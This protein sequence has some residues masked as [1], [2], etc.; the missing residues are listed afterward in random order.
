[1]YT[2]AVVMDRYEYIIRMYSYEPV[3]RKP[4]YEM[5]A[6]PCY[7]SALP[8]K[9]GIFKVFPRFHAFLYPQAAGVLRMS[10]RHEPQKNPREPQ[11]HHGSQSGQDKERHLEEEH[12]HPMA[13]PY[14]HTAHHP[15]AK[16]SLPPRHDAH[17]NPH[18]DELPA[19]TNPLRTSGRPRR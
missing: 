9:S 3:K 4:E 15:Q 13:H 18:G 14:P 6:A 2:R 11:S 19:H 5:A 12:H 16:P 7:E 17:S 10:P 8:T 1:L